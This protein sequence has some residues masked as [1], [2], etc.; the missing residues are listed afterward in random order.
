NG[1]HSPDDPRLEYA[2][3]YSSYAAAMCSPVIPARRYSPRA[4]PDFTNLMDTLDSIVPPTPSPEPLTVITRPPSQPHYSSAQRPLPPY[5]AYGYRKKSSMSPEKAAMIVH[6]QLQQV[7][8][9]AG[10]DPRRG[11]SDSSRSPPK[12]WYPHVRPSD[13]ESTSGIGSSPQSARGYRGGAVSGSDSS[14][15][16]D[17]GRMRFRISSS[18]PKRGASGR[19]YESDPDTSRYRIRQDVPAN[20]RTS[21]RKESPRRKHTAV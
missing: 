10:G 20:Y 1:I 7:Q 11:G 5:P 14:P 19:E 2:N 18:P 8:R 3:P 15:G 17:T 9:V 4:Q 21:P 16:Y 12:S 6:P 13:G